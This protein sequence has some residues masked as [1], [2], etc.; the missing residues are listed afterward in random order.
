MKELLHS[1]GVWQQIL[2]QGMQAAVGV[3]GVFYYGWCLLVHLTNFIDDFLGGLSHPLQSRPALGLF[4]MFSV[5]MLC[6]APYMYSYR[7]I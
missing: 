6:N 4:V 7:I 3:N 5:R 2:L 1:L